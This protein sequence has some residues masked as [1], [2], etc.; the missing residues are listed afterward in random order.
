MGANLG[1]TRADSLLASAVPLRLR[2][3]R[4]TSLKRATDTDRQAG[5]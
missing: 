5:R 2:P 1:A 4:E 3:S